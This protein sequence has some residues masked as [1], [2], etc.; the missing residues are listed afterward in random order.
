MYDGDYDSVATCT[1]CGR[2][3]DCRHGPDGYGFELPYCRACDDRYYDTA[4]VMGA[5]GVLVAVLAFLA[6]LMIYLS[7]QR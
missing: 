2:V 6:G 1:T 3:A 5:K 4:A 7:V